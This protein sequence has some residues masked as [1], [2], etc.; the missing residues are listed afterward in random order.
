MSQKGAGINYADFFGCCGFT[1]LGV[2]LLFDF[3][4]F[5][6]LVFF[7]IVCPVVVWALLAHCREIFKGTAWILRHLWHGLR[8]TAIFCWPYLRR[9]GLYAWQQSCRLFHAA[10]QRIKSG[11][12]P[13]TGT[14]A[15]A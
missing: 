1:I 3:R 13:P 10:W 8:Q 6:T 4:L 2:V 9:F 14:G 12:T 5:L 11:K 7:L 15:A